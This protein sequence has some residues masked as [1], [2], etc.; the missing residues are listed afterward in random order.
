MT[1]KS[2]SR[3]AAKRTRPV[4]VSSVLWEAPSAIYAVDS[5]EALQTLLR[6]CDV[7]P[8]Q[9]QGFLTHPTD[10]CARPALAEVQYYEGG[11]L[12]IVC[13]G[14]EMFER[15]ELGSETILTITHE[16]VHVFQRVCELMGEEAPGAEVQAYAIENITR[17]LINAFM[18]I[19]SQRRALAQDKQPD[20]APTE[21]TQP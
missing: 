15:E 8:V 2:K 13:F 12:C 3:R 10:S 7:P 5:E 14:P 18:A 1:Q 17:S 9:W 21:Q 19:K 6:R 4:S 11:A 16:A 20:L